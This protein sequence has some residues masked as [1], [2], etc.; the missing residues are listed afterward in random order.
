MHR[1]ILATLAQYAMVQPGDLVLCALSGGGDSVAMTHALCQ[2]RQQLG[3]QLA[4]AHF[5]HG[6]RPGDAPA[7]RRLVEDLCHDLGIALV[8]EQGD[9]PAYCREA[10]C[11]TEEGAR[12]LRYDFLQRSAR[13]LGAQKIAT[14]H[15][16]Q[17]TAET[18]LLNLC[19]GTGLGGLGGIPPV[20]GNIIRPMLA[21][22]PG[23][24]T[25]YLQDNALAHAQDPSNQSQAY[26]RNRL[27]SQVLPVLQG[28][29]A[30][31]L[32]HFSQTARSCAQ[33]QAYLE[34]AAQAFCA[35]H[36]RGGGVDASALAKAH[37]AIAQR[38]V[39]WLCA[40]C[41]GGV[42][43]ADARQQVLDLCHKG[44]SAQINLPQ[45]L[46]ARR[47]YEALIVEKPQGQAL[48]PAQSLAVGECLLLGGY[49]ISLWG[50]DAPET[51][52]GRRYSFAQGSL[53]P[54]LQVRP[55]QV[56]DALLL[57]GKHHSIKKWMIEEK[58]PAGRRGTWPLV[59]DENGVA[60]V[61][62]GPARDRQQ[63]PAAWTVVV[64]ER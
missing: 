11:G 30:R 52:P 22:S 36:A 64:R 45:G 26:A 63:L 35:E 49:E 60:L 7:E 23:E 47:E 2:M 54:P 25:A 4:A 51:V 9:T 38:A 21:V 43:S 58:I 31:A 27:R 10:G 50:G 20:R 15:H 17:D 40:D 61:C 13:A 32:W 39:Q 55:R 33:D 48:W 59:C 3:I 44:P 57:G 14:A 5:I 41:G 62:G 56:G 16:L 18:L 24:V 12:Q 28:V 37:P 53:A 29:N 6:L 34:Q 8:V 19:R 42:L 1:K 46:V